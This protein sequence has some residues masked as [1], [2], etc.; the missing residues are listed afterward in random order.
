MAD[1]D[2]DTSGDFKPGFAAAGGAIDASN[3]NEMDVN[4]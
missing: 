4:E 1:N 3:D 2:N